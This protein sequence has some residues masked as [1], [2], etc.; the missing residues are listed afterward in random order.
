MN[1]Y[2]VIVNPI[3]GR[4]AGERLL[5]RVEQILRSYDLNY[6]LVQTEY[7]GHAIE[8]AQEAIKSGYNILVAMGGDGTANE[9]LNGIMHA[10]QNGTDGI[11]LGVLSVGSG[12]D[13]AFS[14][15]VPHDL[16]AG[17]QVLAEDHRR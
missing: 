11:A 7:P 9:V 5:P 4:G 17:C 15:G 3:S 2:K 16:V 14:L 10:K 12:N 8:L 1:R 13:F 6:D